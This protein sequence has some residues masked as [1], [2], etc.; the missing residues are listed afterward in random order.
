MPHR[1]GHQADLHRGQRNSC[2][3]GTGCLRHRLRAPLPGSNSV[4]RNAW[5]EF[6]PFLDYDTEIRKV[7]CS[8]DAIESLKARYRRAIRVRGHFSTEP[9]A[10]N[11]PYLATRSLDQTGTGPPKLSGDSHTESRLEIGAGL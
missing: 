4:V 10:V 7:I 5:S 2:R 6:V 8:T 3:R 9:A 11:R 1:Q